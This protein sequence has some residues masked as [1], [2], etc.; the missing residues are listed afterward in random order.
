MSIERLCKNCGNSFVKFSSVQ[1]LCPKCSYN[2]YGPGLKA[3]K[4]VKR[5]G[6]TTKHWIDT[7]S[8]W[9]AKHQPNHAGYW[10]CAL[11]ISPQCLNYM[12]IDQL[13]LDHILGR[14]RRP[15]LRDD[16]N[17]LQPAC[18]YCNGLK[19]SSSK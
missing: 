4:P 5:I 3:K 2:K 1:T 19:G 14:G 8:K 17:N 12:D 11:H 7:R 16:L 15:D 9:I 18:A 6:K 13:T 10:E